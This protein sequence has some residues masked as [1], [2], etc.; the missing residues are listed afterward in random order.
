M[1]PCRILIRLSIQLPAHYPL[2]TD[3]RNHGVV[4]SPRIKFFA[5][6][7]ARICKPPFGRIPPVTASTPQSYLV[8]FHI[9]DRHGFE[10]YTREDGC[11]TLRWPTTSTIHR[12]SYV[13][14]GCIGVFVYN[15][16]NHSTVD[17][18]YSV[19]HWVYINF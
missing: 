9:M 8:E 5:A 10:P 18:F 15:S 2:P 16:V 11:Q 14:E 6:A 19:A 1:V 12:P 13:Y 3:Y 7:L 4:L 17:C